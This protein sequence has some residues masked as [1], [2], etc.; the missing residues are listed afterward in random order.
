VLPSRAISDSHRHLRSTCSDA[1]GARFEPCTAAQ[2]A[3]DRLGPFSNVVVTNE[4][5]ANAWPTGTFPAVQRSEDRMLWNELVRRNY[6]VVSP[7]DLKV[8]TSGRLK[9]RVAGGFADA[10]ADTWT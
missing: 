6:Q 7:V 5:I 4:S 3:S 2:N 10:M 1:C 9:G 8:A